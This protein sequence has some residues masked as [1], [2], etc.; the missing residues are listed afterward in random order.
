MPE[1]ETP[2]DQENN[3][4]K[5]HGE[6]VQ[7]DE[8]NSTSFNKVSDAGT[9]SETAEKVEAAE[10]IVVPADPPVESLWG[11]LAYGL[12]LPERT[13]R[14][15]SAVVG[16]LV[17]ET[18]ARL[19][20][21]AFRSSR[22]YKLFIQQALDM[23]V[24][25][26]GGV[27]NAAA[28]EAP[29][30]E[31]KLAQKAVGGLLDYVGFATLHLSPITVL[32]VFNDVAYGSGYYLKKLSEELK[33]EGIIDAESSIDHVSD[34]VAA[35]H[36]TSCRA[37]DAV[38]APPI[39]LSGLTETISQLQTEVGKVD[40]THLLPQAEV[41]RLWGEMEAAAR[42]SETGIWDV[43]TT[44]T[45]YAMNRASLTT[46]GALSTVTVAGGILDEHL[47]RHYSSALDE[48]ST[49][50][51]Y[52]TLADASTPYLEA[53]WDNFSDQRETWTQD[54]LTGK[55]F[56]KAW[57]GVRNWWNADEASDDPST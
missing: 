13:A 19:I 21:I 45:M 54:L 22:S 2:D 24:H 36:S 40:P 49:H 39:S 6:P 14:S 38:D 11:T 28:A 23:M 43:S 25:D 8:A 18:A 41:Q 16:G 32:A 17:N 33:R 37:V 57:E 26:V 20:P 27:K 12:S 31:A 55:L 50:G 42:K 51:L 52:A 46:R 10:E 35:L 15:I 7:P 34:L 53:V 44:M 1:I 4:A 56:N 29:T 3:A 30:E 9:P 48:I 47:F 5:P